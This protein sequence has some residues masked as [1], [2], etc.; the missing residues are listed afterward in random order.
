MHFLHRLS[1]DYVRFSINFFQQ[2]F[3]GYEGSQRKGQLLRALRQIDTQILLGK[4][5][6]GEKQEQA[7]LIQPDLV[8]GIWYESATHQV[9]E[10]AT[11]KAV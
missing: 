3:D 4:I 7:R 9:G 1:P 11:L 8:E 6:D 2:H 10:M 5:D